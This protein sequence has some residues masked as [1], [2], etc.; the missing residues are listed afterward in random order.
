MDTDQLESL[1][2]G[3]CARGVK[4]LRRGYSR[5]D[6]REFPLSEYRTGSDPRTLR[7]ALAV[8]PRG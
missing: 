6:G 1:A 3:E 5:S 4:G 7:A 2:R 8:S